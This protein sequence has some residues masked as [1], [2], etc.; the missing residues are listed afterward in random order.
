VSVIHELKMGVLPLQLRRNCKVELENTG[1]Q[2]AFDSFDDESEKKGPSTYGHE[3][4]AP[5][6]GEHTGHW[7][8][9]LALV[10]AVGL[11]TAFF[12]VNKIKARE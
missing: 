12:A 3:S 6:Y 10:I 9:V 2:T 8:G 11:G 1:K 4:L 5:Q 7:I